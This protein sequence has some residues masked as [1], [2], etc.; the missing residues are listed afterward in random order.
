M[1]AQP[2]MSLF[3]AGDAFIAMIGIH[4]SPSSSR[5]LR[6]EIAPPDQVVC[7]RGEGKDPV[8]EA[9]AAMAELAEQADGFHPPEGLLDQ[10]SFPLAHGIA[11]VA[12]GTRRRWHCRRTG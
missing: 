5:P 12:Q 6:D 4:R 11:G 9:A 7:G 2:Q 3:V 8:D 10:F 1:K